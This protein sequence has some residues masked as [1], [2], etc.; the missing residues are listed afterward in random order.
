MPSSCIC[1]KDLYGLATL[2]RKLSDKVDELSSALSSV[3]HELMKFF[4]WAEARKK[5][6]SLS[7][8]LN[9]QVLSCFEVK[10]RRRYGENV[11]ECK[12]F[13]LC[14]NADDL[15][16]LRDPTAWPDSVLI[17]K[18]YFK[19]QD[20]REA[21]AKRRRVVG[22][23][24]SDL[25]VPTATTTGDTDVRSV[26]PSSVE[27]E[28]HL[29]NEDDAT[30]VTNA[31]CQSDDVIDSADNSDDSDWLPV[32]N[33]TVHHQKAVSFF[34]C[35]PDIMVANV[36][37]IRN[38]SKVDERERECSALLKITMFRLHVLLNRGYRC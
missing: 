14:I 17:L 12:A 23:P 22:N 3:T 11:N 38:S 20:Q 16:H 34:K 35:L 7:L 9:V 36:R 21:D 18:W 8:S 10:S 31:E 1:E 4:A 2:I 33:I 37:S 15:V 13:R 27:A 28:I 26:N 30:V 5:S 24:H 32:S 19:P 29:E 6:R 25:P